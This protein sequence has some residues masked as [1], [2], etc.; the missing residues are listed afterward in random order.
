V[1]T[2]TVLAGSAHYFYFYLLCFGQAL[3]VESQNRKPTWWLVLADD[4]SNV[5]VVPPVKITDVPFSDPSSNRDYRS[6]K[7]QFQAPPNVGMFT[8]KL[9]LIS[10]TFV[11]EEVYKDMVVSVFFYFTLLCF[12]TV[13]QP[14][15][16][17]MMYLLLTRM[18][19]VK[20]TRFLNQMRIPWRDRWL[21]C[22]AKR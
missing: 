7:L 2:C 14:S 22:V 6:Y 11:G 3:N 4:K 13:C 12:N 17:S 20:R 19:G 15:S 5:L 21:L 8:W 16:R 1:G 9:C 10:D 18:N